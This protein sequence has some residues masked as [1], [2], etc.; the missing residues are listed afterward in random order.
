MAFSAKG[1]VKSMVMIGANEVGDKTFFIAAVMAMTQPRSAVFG[2]ALAALALMTALFTKLFTFSLTK[3]TGKRNRAGGRSTGTV[4]LCSRGR[5][6]EVGE[7]HARA[8]ASVPCELTSAITRISIAVQDLIT[9]AADTGGA[10]TTGIAS[11]CNFTSVTS[12]RLG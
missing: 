10:I 6:V 7:G 1:F 5:V 4:H 8:S 11:G 3:V 2:G 9:T 12:E